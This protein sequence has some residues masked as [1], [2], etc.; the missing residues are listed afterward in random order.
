MVVQEAIITSKGENLKSRISIVIWLIQVFCL[1][2][3]WE[4]DDWNWFGVFVL[5][6]ATKTNI[7]ILIDNNKIFF[8]WVW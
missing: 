3:L 2:E 8:I 1:T 7:Q 4:L 5:H 6:P